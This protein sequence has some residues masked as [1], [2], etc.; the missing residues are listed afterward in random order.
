MDGPKTGEGEKKSWQSK[1]EFEN[2]QTG[3][4]SAEEEKKSKFPN[5]FLWGH[6]CI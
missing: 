5:A 4:E 6:S 3:L 2:G 1:A